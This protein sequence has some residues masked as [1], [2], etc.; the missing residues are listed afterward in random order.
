MSSSHSLH[1]L[2]LLNSP[3]IVPNITSFTSLLSFILHMCPNKFNFL[4]MI[5]CMMFSLHCSLYSSAHF[6]IR[7]L[8]RSHE[9]VKSIINNQFQNLPCT[10]ETVILFTMPLACHLSW[11]ISLRQLG[12]KHLNL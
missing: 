5:C 4:F 2:P 1:G 11:R 3:S 7:D 8:L 10:F 6:F 12:F 9:P